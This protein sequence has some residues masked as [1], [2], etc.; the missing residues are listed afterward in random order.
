MKILKKIGKVVVILCIELFLLGFV[1][2]FFPNANI[3]IQVGENK[4]LEKVYI[5]EKD[6]VQELEFQKGSLNEYEIMIQNNNFHLEE[7]LIVDWDEKKANTTMN[8]YFVRLIPINFILEIQ[9]EI[10]IGVIY[11]N[12]LRQIILFMV[13]NIIFFCILYIFRRHQVNFKEICEN[14]IYNDSSLK[15]VGKKLIIFSILITVLSI[16]MKPGGD[17]SPILKTL[18]V[19]LSGIDA[20]QFQNIYQIYIHDVE[21]VMWPYNPIMLVFYSLF[22]ILN[23]G[24]SPFY[25]STAFD[26]LPAIFLKIINILLMNGVVLGVISCL[27]EYEMV[28]KENIKKIYLWSIF[29]PLV[30][31]IAIIYIQLDVLPMYCVC[32]GL[33][34]FVKKNFKIETGIIAAILLSLGLFC[35]MQNILLIPTVLL[36]LFITGLKNRKKIRYVM[37]FLLLCFINILNIYVTN[38]VI[39]TFL[40]ANKQGQRIWFT[41]FAYAPKVYIFIT[42]F[43]IIFLFLIN[44]F[45]CSSHINQENFVY[46][47]LLMLG[48]IVLIFSASII[49]TPS[50]LIIAF[51]AFILLMGLEDDWMKRMFISLFSILCACC[52]M[53]TNVGDITASLN[54]FGKEGI[55]TVLQRKFLGTPDEI[56]LNSILFTVSKAAMIAYALLF[57]KYGIKL[58]KKNNKFL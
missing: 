3:V 42:I 5:C 35:K 2:L 9:E 38:G 23:F 44:L 26:I 33:L 30:Y 7:K 58:L 55:F 39:G 46:N 47:S 43:V 56:K 53:F 29:N 50:T 14:F 6:F 28:K 22:G 40:G 45:Q 41:T 1:Q 25:I 18:A 13:Y 12:L 8:N 52:E 51:P 10:W 34:L 17:C 24:Y 20:Y 36:F 49:S 48:A 31:Y 37:A 54:Y 27:L 57:Y 32:M 15:I 19:N 4:E 16:V 21:F 11:N